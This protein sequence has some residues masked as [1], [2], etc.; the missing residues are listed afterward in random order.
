MPGPTNSLVDVAGLAV[1]HADDPRLRT[2]VTVVIAETPVVAS[3]HVMGGAPGT[4]ETDLLA[5]RQTVG[6]ID[7]V[8]LSGGSAFGLDA[9]SGVQAALR[10]R[11]RGFAVGDVR[12]PIVPAAVL[13]D[14]LDGGPKDWGDDPPW[15]AL[16]RAAIDAASTRS[17]PLGSVGAG[18]GATTADLRGGIGSASVVL[19]NGV[20]VAALVAVNAVGTA[21]IGDSG[22]FWAAPHEIGDEFGG[23]GLP[24]PWPADAVRLRLKAAARPGTATT[25][26]VVAT[27]A[28]LT[29]AE[30]ER[31]AVQAHDG[32][33]RALWPAHTPL[34][35]DIVFALATGAHP[36]AEP[37]ADRVA[38]GI[39]AVEVVARAI[40]RGVH[41]ARSA[42]GDALPAWDD[43]WVEEPTPPP[44]VL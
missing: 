19:D 10:A 1:G 42:P 17:V 39:A 26:A 14:L 23:L 38:L 5:A 41:A 33:A 27:D 34:D 13:F 29:K 2:G 35:G 15:R 18:R 36:L 8:V 11:G 9:A 12:V 16:G 4:R 3:C 24:H 6:A 43:L 37:L 40:A 32:F 20:T 22:H 30:C 7:A 28:A 25:L 21:T 31:L 44:L